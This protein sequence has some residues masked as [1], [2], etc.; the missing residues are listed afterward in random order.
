[1]QSMVSISH[2]QAIWSFEDV[3]KVIPLVFRLTKQSFQKAEPFLAQI[4]SSQ[5]LPQSESAFLEARIDEE[6]LLW[7]RKIE[8]LG[9]KVKGL[10]R[11]EFTSS[12][13]YWSWEYPEQ[14]MLYWR[15]H[16]ESF[17]ER[18]KI[19]IT[20]VESGLYS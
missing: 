2:D 7:K 9:G 19:S 15:S 14:S 5:D 10:W 12:S 1:M 11:V 13:G 6:L 18:R 16:E 4:E 8:K 20:D 3:S 17:S